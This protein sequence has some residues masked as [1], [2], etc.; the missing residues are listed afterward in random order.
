MG[1][2]LTQ[3]SK[4]TPL[5]ESDERKWVI[6]NEGN[7]QCFED[8]KNSSMEITVKALVSYTPMTPY[9]CSCASIARSSSKNRLH[10]KAEDWAAVSL[11]LAILLHV[12]AAIIPLSTHH[13][14]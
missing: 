8:D 5:S 6:W 7:R 13:V 4:A 12:K 10:D 14:T 3:H 11:W 2:L 1:S 9:T